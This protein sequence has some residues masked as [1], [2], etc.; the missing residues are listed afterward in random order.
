[1]TV[2]A[3]SLK[4]TVLDLAAIRD[5]DDALACLYSEL[6]EAVVANLR[7]RAS[8]LDRTLYHYADRDC[9]IIPLFDPT[10]PE[11]QA[12]AYVYTD[13]ETQRH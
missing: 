5:F 3:E 10:N 9:W 8:T 11:F 1:M 2:L 4:E 13:G 6:N 12:C 7:E